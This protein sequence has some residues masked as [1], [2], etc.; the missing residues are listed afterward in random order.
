MMLRSNERTLLVTNDEEDELLQTL[1]EAL[2]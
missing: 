2:L 1:R